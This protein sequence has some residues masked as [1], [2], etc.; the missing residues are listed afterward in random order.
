M[1]SPSQ[2]QAPAALLLTLM[3]FFIARDFGICVDLSFSDIFLC[4]EDF[5]VSLC[6]GTCLRFGRLR[7]C[8]SKPYRHEDLAAK[9][10]RCLDE[11]GVPAGLDTIVS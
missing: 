3:L 10:R 4:S 6:L 7:V 5:L 2:P 11:A 1:T 8:L 9:I